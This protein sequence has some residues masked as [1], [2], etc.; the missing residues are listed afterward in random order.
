MAETTLATRYARALIDLGVELRVV[1]TLQGDLARVRAVV[2]AD[3][4]RL[5]RFLAAPVFDLAER[6]RVLVA[7]LDRMGQHKPLHPVV[8]NFLRLI[9]D[10]GRFAAVPEVIRLYD[11]L[12]DENAN[13]E[14]VVVETAE[15]LSGELLALVK[16][17]LERAT[18]RSIVVEPKVNPSLI[19]GIVARVGGKVY[20]ASIKSRLTEIRQQLLAAQIPPEA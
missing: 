2:E 3:G 7:V 15:P 5:L 19:G 10:K 12:A 20:D 6:Q 4:Q 18:G 17:T 8:R 14:R 13:R 9:L 11:R 16:T 1:D